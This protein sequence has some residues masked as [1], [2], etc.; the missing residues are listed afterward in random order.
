MLLALTV[1]L[2]AN[3]TGALLEASNIAGKDSDQAV[4][5]QLLII[6]NLI[7]F[8]QNIALA[9]GDMA[10][11]WRAW[12][13]LPNSRLWKILL[14]IL[15]IAN[16]GLLITGCVEDDIDTQ[17]VLQ[18]GSASFDWIS[19]IVSCVINMLVT[20]F[21]LWK[22]WVYQ[23]AMK[24]L[25]FRGNSS[26]H[27]ILLLLIESGGI[28]CA[29]QL[30][31]VIIRSPLPVSTPVPD[32]WIEYSHVI[33]AVFPTITWDPEKRVSGFR[34]DFWRVGKPW[35]VISARIVR[36]GRIL[37]RGLA[38]VRFTIDSYK[39]PIPGDGFNFLRTFA[40][41]FQLALFFIAS[42]L[43]LLYRSSLRLRHLHH[44]R[45]NSTQQTRQSLTSMDVFESFDFSGVFA[46]TL[47]ADE[48]SLSTFIVDP[49]AIPVNEE[50]E[51]ASSAPL[52]FCVIA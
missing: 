25:S 4:T 11:I 37:L 21:I 19:L 16:M 49:L 45:A 39:F 26:V 38:I 1:N 48:A 40:R 51:T 36:S 43:H 14:T 46:P 33:D 6:N 44:N 35:H 13:L 8:T 42:P 3:T 15:M 5:T 10:V 32:G 22:W 17:E 9:I 18:G 27:K 24:A 30:L 34:S 20:L 41:A 2:I 12:V 52:G 50:H 28:F 31:S 7:N 47:A 23:K 29:V